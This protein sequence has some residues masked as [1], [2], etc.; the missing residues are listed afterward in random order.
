MSEEAPREL[1]P[2]TVREFWKSLDFSDLLVAAS[3]LWAAA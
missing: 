2:L 3:T 1:P